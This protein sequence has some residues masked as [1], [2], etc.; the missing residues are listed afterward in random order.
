MTY[1]RDDRVYYAVTVATIE[2]AAAALGYAAGLHLPHPL[3]VMTVV[4]CLTAALTAPFIT[5]TGPPPDH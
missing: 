5:P 3:A 4:G 2:T 1:R